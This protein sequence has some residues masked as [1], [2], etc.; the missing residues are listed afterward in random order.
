[1]SKKD[2][3]TEK[4]FQAQ[5]D[6]TTRYF[7]EVVKPLLP[8]A[9]CG[10]A[11]LDGGHQLHSVNMAPQLNNGYIKSSNYEYRRRELKF[12]HYTN[13]KSAKSILNSAIMRM[14]SLSSMLDPQELSFALQDVIPTKTTG[15]I[16]EYKQSLFT[17]SMNEFQKEEEEKDIWLDYGDSGKGV[18]LVLSF[19]KE[20]SA[21]WNQHYISKIKYREKDLNGLKKFHQ[22]HTVLA[23]STHLQIQGQVKNFLLP[24]AAFHKTKG[25]KNEREVRLLVINKDSL[26]NIEKSQYE[27]IIVEKAENKITKS[28]IELLLNP[29]NKEDYKGLRPIPKIE[30]IILGPKLIGIAEIKEELKKLAKEGLGYDVEVIKSKI[31]I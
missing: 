3:E 28:Y 1:M 13:V 15:T 12:V 25:F 19:D 9:E 20:E 8:K 5:K 21:L 27:P 10:G 31:L 4:F 6:L 30:K 22:R 11:F 18:G 24:L 17:L 2:I 7:K 23:D 14:Y 29:K 26:L 16:D